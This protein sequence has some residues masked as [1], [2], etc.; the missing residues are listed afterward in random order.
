E[1]RLND[2]SQISMDWFWETDEQIRFTYVSQR[3]FDITGVPSSKVIGKT[4]FELVPIQEQQQWPDAWKRHKE[5]IDARRPFRNFEYGIKGMHG[6]TRYVRI[7]GK[8]IYTTDGTFKGY[9]G[10][11]T[12]ETDRIEAQIALEQ[13]QIE[14]LQSEK[15]ASI[16]QL[17]AG[18]AH[19][20]NTPIG[21]ITLNL[22]TL[23]EYAADLIRLI[24]KQQHILHKNKLANDAELIRLQDEIDI[25]YLKEDLPDLIQQSSDGI[26]KISQIVNGLQEYASPIMDQKKQKT[27][28]DINR[29]LEQACDSITRCCSAKKITLQTSFHEVPMIKGQENQFRQLFASLLQNAEQAINHQGEITITTQLLAEQRQVVIEIKDSGCGMD[30]QTINKIFDPFFTT[31]EVGSGTGLGLSMAQGIVQSHNGTITVKSKPNA[32]TVLIIMLPFDT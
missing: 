21:F 8:P 19:E 12:D 2:L 11:G 25:D 15:M 27:T 18:A 5:D 31:R 30:A 4:R 7:N 17:A 28:V 6:L 16:G 20:I 1:Q 29:L 3:Y 9:V 26:N 22:Q 13:T 14:L 24:D 23:Q 10:T 32:G